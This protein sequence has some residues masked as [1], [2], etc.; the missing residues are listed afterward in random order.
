MSQRYLEV[1]YRKGRPLAAYL[2]L[3][4]RPGQT[5]HKSRPVEAG[6]VVDLARNGDPIGIEITSPSVVTLAAVNRVLRSLG[7]TPLSRVDFG[8]LR[9]AS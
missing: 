3:P 9:V 5:S 6:M 1:T 8:P 2:S 7:L 4:R